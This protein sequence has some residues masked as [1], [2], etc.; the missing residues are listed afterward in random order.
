MIGAYLN[1]TVGL[2][3][4]RLEEQGI[5]RKPESDEVQARSV[6]VAL[7]EAARA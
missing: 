1:N 7:R 3:V 2:V 6:T 5:M 4:A